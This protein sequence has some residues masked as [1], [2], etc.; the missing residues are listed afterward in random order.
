MP[1]F[2]D[3]IL[4]DDFS[5]DTPQSEESTEQTEVPSE[6]VQ[7]VEDT[8]PTEQVTETPSIE[9]PQAFKIKYNHE[10]QEISYDDAVPLIQKGMNFDKAVERAKQDAIDQYIASQGYEWNGQPITTE[11]Q[12]KQALM[13]QELI[14]QYQ[15]QNLPPEVIQKLIKLE[16]FQNEYEQEKTAKQQE[17]QKNAEYMEFF[18]YF[19]Q[20]NGRDFVPGKD[21][22][23]ESVL[24]NNQVPLK[25]AFME[26][27]N[28]LLQQQLQTLKQN[29]ANE[30]KAPVGS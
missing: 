21:I 24:T 10:E 18:D 30:S 20:A 19:R 16:S 15:E 28:Q 12:Y 3:A 7:T 26:H 5:M 22:I 6:S 1:D 8:T 13:E 2:E 17:E 27:Q 11:K 4:P 23:P 14:Q 9:T 29:K 25:Y